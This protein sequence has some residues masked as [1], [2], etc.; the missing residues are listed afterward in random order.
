MSAIWDALLDSHL[1]VLIQV[2]DLGHQTEGHGR[3]G[4]GI[5]L[6]S[7]ELGGK[8]FNPLTNITSLFTYLAE[9][10]YSWEASKNLDEVQNT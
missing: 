10:P 5:G 8:R 1:D 7:P 3:L 4:F 6:S 9:L 2:M